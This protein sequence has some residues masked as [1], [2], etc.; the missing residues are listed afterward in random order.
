MDLTPEPHP[1]PRSGRV[2]QATFG[3][4]TQQDRDW[5]NVYQAATQQQ[6]ADV[7]AAFE[8]ARA[9]LAAQGYSVAE[10]D[11]AEA[12]VAAITRYMTQS[13]Q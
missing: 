2:A 9:V 3:G 6:K 10:D 5:H 4:T 1:V 12:L 11:R 13:Q 7:I 8:A